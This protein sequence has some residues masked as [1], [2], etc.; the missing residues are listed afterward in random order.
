MFVCVTLD[1]NTVAFRD[2]AIRRFK[3]LKMIKKWFTR[4]RTA[5]QSEET[6]LWSEAVNCELRLP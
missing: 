4:H 2:D 3:S 6:V 1:L 5:A